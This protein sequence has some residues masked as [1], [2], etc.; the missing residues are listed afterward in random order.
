MWSLAEASA[1]RQ[2]ARIKRQKA[3]KTRPDAE[4]GLAPLI[5]F[6]PGNGSS[7]AGLDGTG[8]LN[9]PKTI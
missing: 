8:V 3:D 6:N 4:K 1:N 5:P 7:A 2:S 9:F